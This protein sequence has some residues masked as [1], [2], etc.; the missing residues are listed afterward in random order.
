MILIDL[1]NIAF[2]AIHG[3][4]SVHKNIELDET[5]IRT[6]TY[7]LLAETNQ[8]FKKDFGELVVTV[9]SLKY[10]RREFFPYYKAGRKKT[11][12][13]SIINWPKIF[14]AMDQIKQ[15]IQE[16]FPYKYI[17]VPGAEADDIIG[18]V[19]YH[20]AKKSFHE[21]KVL[22][23]SNDKD[24]MQLQQFPF[25]KQ[26]DLIKRKWI[27]CDAP[28]DYIFEHI[29]K[30]DSGDGIPNI[31]S[32]DNCFVEGIRQNVLNRNKIASLMNIQNEPDNKYFRNWIRNNTLIRLDQTPTDIKMK[33]LEKLEEP[34][35]KNRSKLLN[36]FMKNKLSTLIEHL[37]NF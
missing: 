9:D 21:H 6:I 34:N 8:K 30:G 29:L 3:F 26:Y 11:R 13:A 20:L 19:C 22:I 4:V 31:L 16:Y 27:E 2:S 1:N 18:V 36:F 12:D 32:P 10:W 35:N 23:V 37:N 14:S 33:I 5:V 28:E 24:F 17:E 25:I 15:E 7:K